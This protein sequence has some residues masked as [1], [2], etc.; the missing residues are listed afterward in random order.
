MMTADYDGWEILKFDKKKKKQKR[1]ERKDGSCKLYIEF[2]SYASFNNL[3]FFPYIRKKK[4]LKLD[5]KI[6]IL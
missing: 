4:K 2:D 5:E 3:N 6:I 1:K